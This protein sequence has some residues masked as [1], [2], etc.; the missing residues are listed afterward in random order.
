MNR[1]AGDKCLSAYADLHCRVQRRLF[2]EVSAGRSAVSL[3]HEYPGRHGIPARMFNS[4]RVS[5]EGKAAS[6]QE[7]MKLV[8]DELEGR[9][10]PA[11]Q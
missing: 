4:V 5:L 10:S 11:L 7:V 9:I 2:A 6:I 8:R 3:K 1:T